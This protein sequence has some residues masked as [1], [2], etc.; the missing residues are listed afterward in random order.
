MTIGIVGFG[1]IFVV[2]LGV[3]IAVVVATSRTKDKGE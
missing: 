2:A 3:A 1:A